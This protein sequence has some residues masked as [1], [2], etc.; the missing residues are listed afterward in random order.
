MPVSIWETG[1]QSIDRRVDACHPQESN[2]TPHYNDE[3]HENTQTKRQ[4][5]Q[6]HLVKIAA[7]PEW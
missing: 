6:P 4:G 7:L 2:H 3:E 5:C 1:L